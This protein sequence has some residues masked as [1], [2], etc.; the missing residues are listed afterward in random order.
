VHT[1]SSDD[2]LLAL[3]HEEPLGEPDIDLE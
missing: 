2:M 1:Q 3:G